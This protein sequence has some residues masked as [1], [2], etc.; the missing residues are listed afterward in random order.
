M[1]KDS[2]FHICMKIYTKYVSMDFPGGS[3]VKNGG[4]A[5]HSFSG[6]PANARDTGSI[7]GLGTKISHAL[8][9]DY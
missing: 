9:P 2:I 6:L 7:P 8:V 4:S 5:V 1:P 3:L